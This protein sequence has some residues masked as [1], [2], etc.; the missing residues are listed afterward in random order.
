[1]PIGGQWTSLSAR[2]EEWWDSSMAAE[3]TPDAETITAGSLCLVTAADV[4]VS[5]R[6]T[7][8]RDVT[9]W[10]VPSIDFTMRY[11]PLPGTRVTEAVFVGTGWSATMCDGTSLNGQ[12]RDREFG[13]RG[14]GFLLDPGRVL[15]HADVL[16]DEPAPH[17]RR[18]LRLREPEVSSVFDR[19]GVLVRF[20]EPTGPWLRLADDV[21]VLGADSYE[22][23]IEPE[24]P[25]VWRWD[26]L[27]DQRV[28]RRLVLTDVKQVERDTALQ[29]MQQTT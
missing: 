18:I 22:A 27:Q 2:F 21:V 10:R 20:S 1:V 4:S 28:I 24:A 12:R 8:N 14:V 25:V 9:A 11:E 7:L 23:V 16:S 26:A 17:G 29:L 15:E 19:D 3:A 6:P 5:R 13:D